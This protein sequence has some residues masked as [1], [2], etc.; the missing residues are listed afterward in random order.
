[1]SMKL[2]R[3]KPFTWN[4]TK[5]K[6]LGS[7]M[8]K[9]AKNA[10]PIRE[11]LSKASAALGCTISV[12]TNRWYGE[13]KEIISKQYARAQQLAGIKSQVKLNLE[14]VEKATDVK[15]PEVKSEVAPVK[16]EEKTPKAE[17]DQVF[18]EKAPEATPTVSSAQLLEELKG[19]APVYNAL[20]FLIQRF[21]K[22]DADNASLKR[23]CKGKDRK[24]AERDET[25]RALNER[26]VLHEEIRQGR[27]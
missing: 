8:C 12:A 23:A 9:S 18:E 5:D 21:A 26:N 17:V 3:S 10:E 14:V 6:K 13:V 19:N 24:I 11:G 4:A 20:T 15:T 2:V 22:M 25:I 16:A 27:R 7:I 1:M